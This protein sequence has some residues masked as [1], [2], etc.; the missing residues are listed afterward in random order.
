MDKE[1]LSF[2]LLIACCIIVYLVYG[3]IKEEKEIR[4]IKEFYKRRIRNLEV[5]KELRDEFKNS[6]EEP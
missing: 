6:Y 5:L 4:A 1:L 2:I 3:I